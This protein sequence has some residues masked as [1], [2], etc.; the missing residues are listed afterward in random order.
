MELAIKGVFLIDLF[1][2][3]QLLLKLGVELMLFFELISKI[4]DFQVYEFQS[5]IQKLMLIVPVLQLSHHP[6]VLRGQLFDFLLL[7]IE[8]SPMPLFSRSQ[9]VLKSVHLFRLPA[10]FL[11]VGPEQPLVLSF[12]MGYLV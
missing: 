5:F 8:L 6:N 1:R 9:V 11:L 4:F 10:F 12:E 3:S 2:C 7:L